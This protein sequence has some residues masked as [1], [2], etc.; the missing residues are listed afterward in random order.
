MS[1]SSADAYVIA[2]PRIETVGKLLRDEYDAGALILGCA[3]MGIY[4]VWLQDL[5]RIPIIDPCWAGLGMLQQ[6]LEHLKI[7]SNLL[8]NKENEN[9]FRN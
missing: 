6:H 1:H 3:G 4:R 2:R 9:G 8:N 5:L 7:N